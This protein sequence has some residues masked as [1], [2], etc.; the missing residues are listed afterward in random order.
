MTKAA[1]LANLASNTNFG[2]LNIYRGGTGVGEFD[3]SG[4][5]FY[6]GTGSSLQL[7][8]TPVSA[9]GTG[10]TTFPVNTAIYANSTNSLTA[11]VLPTQGG[12]T[13]MATFNTAG[14]LYA[15]DSNTLTTG[16]LPTI[17]GGTGNLGLANNALLVGHGFD[18]IQTIAPG[19]ANNVLI[20]DG[21]QW[22]AA[23]AVSRG[24]GIIP[25]P[26]AAN[27]ILIDTGNDWA[28]VPSNGLL[29]SP[30]AVN[31]IMVSNGSSWVSLASKGILGAVGTVGNVLTSDGTSWTSQTNPTIGASQTWRNQLSNRAFGSAYTNSTS[32]P[33]MVSITGTGVS[34]DTGS[35][36]L[37]I[38]GVTMAT[39]SSNNTVQGI[40]PPGAAYIVT[41]AGTITLTN[42]A[43]LS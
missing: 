11:G 26:S 19:A 35:M 21:T 2:I 20:S 1:N 16:T 38:S 39:A 3:K 40:V 13:G 18:P 8:V 25:K 43:E 42:W 36:T 28:S 12:G 5:L 41:S 7:G 37:S 34:T 10:M 23:N 15:L 9:G 31:N 22:Y 33:I 4:V 32:K 24:I 14:A 30:G 29:V 17:S 27:N 6:D